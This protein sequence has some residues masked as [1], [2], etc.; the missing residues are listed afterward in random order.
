MSW[1]VGVARHV[2]TVT[3][4]CLKVPVCVL[5]QRAWGGG[6]GRGGG[7][8]H[9]QLP[10][11]RILSPYETGRANKQKINLKGDGHRLQK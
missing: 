1:S 5:G 2:F 10:I 9:L 6:G 4:Q 8:M 7:G 11:K 3:Y